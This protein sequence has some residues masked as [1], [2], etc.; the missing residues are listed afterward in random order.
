MTRIRSRCDIGRVSAGVWRVVRGG[1]EVYMWGRW[2]ISGVYAT[3]VRDGFDA[4][5]WDKWRN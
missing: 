2:R 4:Y 5:R 3:L 1:F